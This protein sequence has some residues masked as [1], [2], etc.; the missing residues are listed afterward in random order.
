LER[1]GHRFASDHS[2]TEVLIYAYRQWGEG[3]LERLNGMWAFAIY[4]R[5]ARKLFLSRDRFGEKPLFFTSR[6]KNFAFASELTALT[7]HSAISPSISKIALQKYFAYGYIPAPFSIFEGIEKLPAGCSLSLS[8]ESGAS[9]ISRYWNYVLEP[10]ERIPKN[11]EAEWGEELVRLL[12]VAVKSRLMAD[13]DLGILLSG[14]IDSSIIAALAAEESPEPIKTFSIGFEEKSFD[15]SDYAALVADAVGSQHHAETLSMEKS[16]ALIPGIVARLDEPMG[17]SSLIPTCLVSRTARKGVSV[18]L[19]G[20]GGDELFAGYDPFA[21]LATARRYQQL[22]PR[23]LHPAITHLAGCLPVS[24]KNM[25]RGFKINRALSALSHPAPL[26][27]PI[28]MATLP[29]T[30]LE[31]LFGE[32]I[33]LEEIY[34]EAISAWESCPQDNHVDRLSQ[35]FIKLYLEDDILVKTDRASMMHGLEVRAPFLDIDLV[36]FVRR[37]PWRFKYRRG[38]RKYLLKKA[39]APLLPKAILQR[40]KKGFGVPVGRWFQQKQLTIEGGLDFPGIRGEAAKTF[41]A[42]HLAGRV[43]HRLFLWNYWLLEKM[44]LG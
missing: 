21:A 29:P 14:G 32:K 31:R 41:L 8:L 33:D 10:F 43:D 23:P 7:R 17:D 37:L 13:V 42:D 16:R 27:G 26:W 22:V 15:E 19:G 1:E 44:K 5:V 9:K 2:D 25:S 6:G 12:R 39:V 20:D 3:M 40:P 24:H 36:D 34:A 4:D 28:W 35:F 18:A 11:P 30:D 38:Q